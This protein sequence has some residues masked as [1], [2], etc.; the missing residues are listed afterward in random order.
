MSVG[1]RVT[2][3]QEYIG[4]PPSEVAVM[5]IITSTVLWSTRLLQSTPSALHKVKLYLRN[6]FLSP[7]ILW[8]QPSCCLML[9]CQPFMQNES[10]PAF[11]WPL[12]IFYAAADGETHTHI[13]WHSQCSPP[14]SKL[15]S[16]LNFFL[17]FSLPLLVIYRTLLHTTTVQTSKWL[18][19]RP[20]PTNR[21][22]FLH[23]IG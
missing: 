7:K 8:L 19:F 18:L 9:D 10:C 13:H 3:S 14:R 21:A 6:Y 5:L 12:F 15:A 23:K 17:N 2:L 20:Y 22:I 11:I 1:Y 4:K 16:S